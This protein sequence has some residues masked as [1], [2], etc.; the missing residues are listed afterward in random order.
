MR[1][2][3]LDKE[4]C[5]RTGIAGIFPERD[6]LS[7]LVGAVLAGQHDEWAHCSSDQVLA[8]GSELARCC[9]EFLGKLQPVG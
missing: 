8:Q 9:H 7:R 3:R 6:A 5:R 4:I 2:K 1:K